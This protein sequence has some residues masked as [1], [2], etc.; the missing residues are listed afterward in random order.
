MWIVLKKHA[1]PGSQQKSCRK[2]L[3]LKTAIIY[4]LFTNGWKLLATTVRIKKSFC[5]V[6]L[7]IFELSPAPESSQNKV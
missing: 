3:E 7:K 6:P 4:M 2:S 5:I 1:L